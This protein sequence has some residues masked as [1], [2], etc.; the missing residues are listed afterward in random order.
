MTSFL[1]KSLGCKI[2]QYDGERLAEKLRQFGLRQVDDAPDM[3]ILNGCSVTGR[4]SQKA[5]QTLRAAK[6]R[7]PAVKLILAGCEARLLTQ[8]HEELAEVDWLLK[9]A[10]PASIS[11][12]LAAL[13]FDVQAE[14]GSTVAV[15]VTARTRAFLKVQD[16]CSQFCSYCIVAHLRGPEWSRP[17]ADAVAEARRLVEEGHRELVL[18]GIH[19]GHYQPSLL[20]L[21]TELEEIDGL[22]R[23][24]LSSIE[25]IEVTDE[26]IDWVATSPKACAH[27][28]LPLQSGSDSILRAMRRPY[29]SAD[30]AAVVARIRA[31]MPFAGV[32]TDLIVGFPGETNEQFA[33]T[34]EF[35]EKIQFSRIH[36]F[37]FSPRDGTPAATMSGQID[38]VSKNRRSDEVAAVWQKSALAFYQRFIGR[39][40]E[41]LWETDQAGIVHGFSREYI[42]C[43]MTAGGNMLNR[44][45][46][47]RGSKAANTG[48]EVAAL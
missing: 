9:D 14:P 23:I 37:K 25:S 38:N 29:S 3:F 40:L 48:L 8:R 26:L 24:R 35:L 5:R 27:M 30:F 39:E 47:V 45:S 46:H 28:H 6:R 2:S 20:P 36:I 1:I 42:P 18:T 16:G 33:E 34:L 17:I 21:L 12:M 13:S 11:A 44:I 41:V 31:R 15:P 19:L 10:E 22:D 32:T 4:A 43:F 7:W